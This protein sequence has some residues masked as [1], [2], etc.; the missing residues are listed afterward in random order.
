MNEGEVGAPT[1]A[2]AMPPWA[3]P[4]PYIRS[5]SSSSP[6]AP[7][8]REGSLLPLVIPHG[9]GLARY[10]FPVALSGKE[11]LLPLHRWSEEAEVVRW[12]ERVCDHGC[13]ATLRCWT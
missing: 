6:L 3:A 10:M 9:L 2:G 8:P 13:T 1:M 12:T 11:L 4:L 7:P 5:T